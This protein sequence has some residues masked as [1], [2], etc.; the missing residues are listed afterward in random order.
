MSTDTPNSTHRTASADAGTTRREYDV[1][2]DAPAHD[3]PYCEAVIPTDELLTLHV[4][5]EHEDRATEAELEAYED[6]FERES[7]QV[8]IYHLKVI[9]MV[10]AI[11]F[12]FLFT[13]SAVL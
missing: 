8:F 11:Y 6:T 7:N 10:V 1:P 12:V 13:Y 4:G 2:P 9:V 3:C 5:I